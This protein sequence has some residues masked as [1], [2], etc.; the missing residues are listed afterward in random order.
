M[1]ATG[2]AISKD[3][4]YL[5]KAIEAHLAKPSADAAICAIVKSDAIE[6]QL[7]QFEEADSKAEKF[8]EHYRSTF[9]F[10][11]WTT[12]VGT[13][14]GA[15]TLLPLNELQQGFPRTV[16]GVLQTLS[17]ISTFLALQWIAFR[18][19]VD[20]WLSHR[21][22][23]EAQRAGIFKSI[24]AARPSGAVPAG[25]ARQKLEL[26][27]SA[28]VDDQLDY[29]NK[30]IARHKRA[31]GNLTTPRIIAYVLS[32][33]VVLLAVAALVKFLSGVLISPDSRIVHAANMLLFFADPPRWQLGLGAIASSIFAHASA[34]SLMDQ[35]ERN[36]ALYSK[37]ADKVRAYVDDNYANI[38]TLSSDDE[39]GERAVMSFFN[40][41]RDILQAEHS[42]WLLSRPAE[43]PAE[44][45]AGEL[46]AR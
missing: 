33:V 13:I 2:A 19:P 39:A 45:R 1:I 30:A 29:F 16:A 32:F 10:A 37:T 12:T 40:S 7:E 23:A 34:R 26:I 3:Q 9:R 5:R 24:L 4:L 22:E 43:N 25:L 31:A 21:A 41:V 18:Q 42:V 44:G 20:K 14:V 35:D 17:V 28:Y 15:L 46:S 27:K 11:L 36:A 8:Q 6:R 38:E